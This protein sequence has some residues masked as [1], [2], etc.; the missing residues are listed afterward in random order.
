MRFSYF[1]KKKNSFSVC[2]KVIQQR[3]GFSNGTLSSSRSLTP[4][5]IPS[6]AFNQSSPVSNQVRLI[7]STHS[8]PSS[9]VAGNINLAQTAPASIFSSYHVPTESGTPM[10]VQPIAQLAQCFNSTTNNGVLK[11][12]NNQQQPSLTNNQMDKRTR[13]FKEPMGVKLTTLNEGTALASHE[14]QVGGESPFNHHLFLCQ[15]SIL[16]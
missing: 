4:Q 3:Y 12:R 2:Q 14:S 13:S 9:Y 11:D 7:T 5:S 6:A 8:I 10:L 1:L 16:D 15:H